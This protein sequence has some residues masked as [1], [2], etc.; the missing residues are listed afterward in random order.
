MKGII[1]FIIV[2][3]AVLWFIGTDNP[4]AFNAKEA[5]KNGWNK[6]NNK[7]NETVDV[8]VDVKLNN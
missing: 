7:V 6:V 3:V 2:V 8:D 4:H 1:K 5:I